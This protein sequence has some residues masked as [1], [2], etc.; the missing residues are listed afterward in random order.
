MTQHNH[1]TNTRDA[2]SE[3]F[4]VDSGLVDAVW[5]GGRPCLVQIFEQEISLLDTETLL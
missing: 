4:G 5:A 2:S 1:G 3:G